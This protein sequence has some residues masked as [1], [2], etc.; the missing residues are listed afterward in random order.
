[1]AD[2]SLLIFKREKIVV[3]ILVYVDDILLIGLDSEFIKG[4]VADLN[5]QFSLKDLGELNY[6]LGI[7]AKR[8]DAGLFLCQSKYALEIL[9][10]A[11]MQDC[12]GVSTPLA[13]GTSLFA[14]DSPLFDRPTLYRSIIGELQYLTLTKPNISYSVKKLSQ[15][16]KKP[17]Q[18]QWQAVEHVLRYVQCTLSYGIMF[19]PSSVLKLEAFSDAD[20]AGNLEEIN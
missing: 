5:E 11:S 12:N 4:L 14:G 7:E 10:K 18:I 2:S 1:M 3:Y 20:W 8:N 19:K 16:L 17:T 6:F 9:H 13:V 15:F